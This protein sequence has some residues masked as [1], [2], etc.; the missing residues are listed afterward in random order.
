M[1]VNTMGSIRFFTLWARKPSSSSSAL[2]VE[3]PR[4]VTGEFALEMSMERLW[5]DTFGLPQ[6]TAYIF[7][8][9][10]SGG[11]SLCHGNCHLLFRWCVFSL[12]SRVNERG[13][14]VTMTQSE[15]ISQ[16]EHPYP[17]NKLLLSTDADLHSSA[18]KETGNQIGEVPKPSV[19]NAMI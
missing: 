2:G 18:P 13:P 19:L 5:P 12:K 4:L 17:W 8:T 16:Q 14:N 15:I 7:L 1:V 10:R 6:A 9:I 3:R 11:V